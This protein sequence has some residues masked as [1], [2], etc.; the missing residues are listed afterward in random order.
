MLDHDAGAIAADKIDVAPRADRRGINTLHAFNSLRLD[1][2]LA[3]VGVVTRQD[4]IIAGEE[5]QPVV[6]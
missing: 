4:R 6:V 2:R 1:D 3:G 5:V